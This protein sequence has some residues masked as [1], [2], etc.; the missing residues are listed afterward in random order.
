[1]I[2]VVIIITVIVISITIISIVIDIIITI[3]VIIQIIVITIIIVIN[4]IV[5]VIRRYREQRFVSPGLEPSTAPVLPN[6]PVVARKMINQ[7]DPGLSTVVWSYR[8]SASLQPQQGEHHES[9]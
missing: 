2:I 9:R 5:I 1:M 3:I 8:Y 6:E 4:I 7:R